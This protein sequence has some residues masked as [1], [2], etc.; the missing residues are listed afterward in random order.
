MALALLAALALGFAA[1]KLR[2][3]SVAAPTLSQETILHLTGR[4]ESVD[5]APRGMRLVV[6]DLRSGGF[7]GFVPGR[8]RITVTKGGEAFHAGDGISLTARLLPPPAPSEPGDSDFVR[9]L[10]F[11]RIGAVGFSYGAPIPAPLASPPGPFTRLAAAIENLRQTMTARIRAALPGSEGAIASA[12]I[13]G[14]RGGIDQADQT[15]LRDAGLAHV[16]A[17]A[18][19]HMAL[20]GLGLFWLV[21]AVLAAFPAIALNYPIK[22]WAAGAALLGAGFYLVISGA[23]ASATRAF[24]MLAMMLLAILFDRPSLSMRSLALA[25]AILLLLRPESIIEPGFQMSFAA[26]S[27]LIAVAEWER[28]RRGAIP[29]GPLMRYLGAIAFTSLVGSLATMPFAIFT[30]NRATH[31]AVLGNL[32]A[33]PVMG[34]WVMPAAALSVIAMPFGLETQPLHL[35]GAG[36]NVMLAMGRFVSGLP[37]AVTPSRAFP[38]SALGLIALGGLWLMLWR[39]SWRWWGLAP[40]AIGLLVA[41]TARPPDILVAD[42]AAT[43]AVRGTDGKLAFPRRPRDTF[44]ATR[45]LERDGDARAPRDALGGGRCD[46]YSCVTNRPEGLIALPFRPEAVAEDCTHAAILISAVPVKNCAGPKLVLDSKIIAQGEGYAVTG[47]K[48]E[49]VRQSR[50]D[51]PWSGPSRDR[52]QDPWTFHHQAPSIAHHQA[53]WID[54]TIHRLGFCESITADQSHQLALHLDAVRAIEAGFISRVGGFERDGVATAAQPLQG[55]FGIVHQRHNDLAG[56]GG[57]DFLD[58]DGIAVQNPG[59]DHGIAG[60]FQGVMFA[61]PDH[62][63]RHRHVGN[64][65]LQRLDRRARRD[66]AYQRDIDGIFAVPHGAP[67]RGMARVGAAPAVTGGRKNAL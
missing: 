32:L 31:Y 53:P 12:L 40:V 22:K 59:I 2:Q 62:A 5:P 66:P 28:I 34:F 27:A 24:V 33:M 3:E 15:A 38:A 44:S 45:W 51:R 61:A 52:R 48:A 23:S 16:L 20:V 47:G 56:I 35:M 29:Q 30:F 58:D 11:Q 8:A 42:D 25:A 18:G 63:A 9:D 67:G 65:V 57:G 14:E 46:A 41:L 19:L 50:G 4:V 21:R 17:I 26:V 36:L 7:A 39:K 13:T 49:S 60:D 10:Y 6:D 1:A 54:Y 55:G 64:A 37:G 43:V